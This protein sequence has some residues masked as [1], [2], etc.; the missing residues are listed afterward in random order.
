MMWYYETHCVVGT[1]NKVCSITSVNY[2][3]F[4]GAKY[5]VIY[6]KRVFFLIS[7]LVRK[8]ENFRTCL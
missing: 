2:L 4:S 8:C 5:I 3:S 6:L 1:K 7:V